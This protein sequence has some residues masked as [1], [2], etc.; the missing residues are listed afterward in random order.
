MDLSK[1]TNDELKELKRQTVNKISRYHNMQLA[2]KILLN[3]AYG[4]SSNPYFHFYSDILAES[5]T[6]SGQLS[7]R[8]IANKL[9]FWLNK[10]LKTHDIDYVIAVDTDSNYLTLND[11][12][13][14]FLPDASKEKIISWI[15]KICKEVIEPYI[16]SSYAELAEMMNAYDQKMKMKRE[17][18]ADRAIWTGKK[19]YIMN[20]WDLEGVRYPEPIIKVTGI[21]TVRSNTPYICREYLKKCLSIIMKESEEVLHDYIEEC[22]NDFYGRRF[23]EVGKPSGVNGISAYADPIK[24]Y[25]KGTPWHVRGSLMYNHA[26]QEYKLDKKYLLIGDEDKIKTC[27]LTMPN[28]IHENV[29]SVPSILPPEFKIERYIDYD[30]QFEVTFLKPLRKILDVIGWNTEKRISLFDL[31]DD[32]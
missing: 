20:V 27:Y 13:M 11:L 31:F 6:L 10:K 2:K 28:I 3:S 18:I 22:R 9:N 1:L 8:F 19:R 24:I 12:V 14:Q 30:Q 29:L 26:I 4:A 25:K 32:L 5:I 23:D 17:A 16:D 15:D 7:I 21:E